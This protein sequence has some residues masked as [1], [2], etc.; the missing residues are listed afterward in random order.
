M[1]SVSLLVSLKQPP[2]HGCHVGSISELVCTLVREFRNG[3]RALFMFHPGFA[4]RFPTQASKQR[5]RTLL[6]VAYGWRG[7]HAPLCSC[8]SC[9]LTRGIDELSSAHC[10]RR[11]SFLLQPIRL[12]LLFLLTSTQAKECIL[13][14][15]G[16]NERA[17]GLKRASGAR[18]TAGFGGC[19]CHPNCNILGG[20]QPSP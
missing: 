19:N 5:Q 11:R 13:Q 2:T 1:A 7:Q 14:A 12:L 15:S 6:F 20:F 10:V 17:P 3:E 8:K 9:G 4:S 16:Q 18:Y